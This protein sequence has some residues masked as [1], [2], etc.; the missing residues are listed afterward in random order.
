MDP[1]LICVG[2]IIVLIIICIMWKPAKSETP[3]APAEHLIDLA[4]CNPPP[5]N[6][7]PPLTPAP[8]PAPAPTVSKFVNSITTL[9][10]R[11]ATPES[12]QAN[13][14]TANKDLVTAHVEGR[15]YDAM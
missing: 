9:P 12:T 6:D 2:I 1:I 8:A 3:K 5:P 11:S 4:G 15:G 14:M 7:A 10:V 13:A